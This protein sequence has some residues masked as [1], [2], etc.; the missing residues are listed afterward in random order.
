MT[1]KEIRQAFDWKFITVLLMMFS[2][3]ATAAVAHGL[4]RNQLDVNTGELSA[5]RDA[6]ESVRE[7][8]QQTRELI[9][10][11]RAETRRM[12]VDIDT[13]AT[14]IKEQ[15]YAQQEMSISIAK[16]AQSISDRVQH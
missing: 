7:Q 4:A 5:A 15:S 16:L 11:Q 1:S 13:L 14:A 9:A 3:V 10:E 2:M 6:Q 8:M 12:R